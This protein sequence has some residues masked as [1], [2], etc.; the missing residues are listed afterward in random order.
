MDVSKITIRKVRQN[1]ASAFPDIEF[2]YG[3]DGRRGCSGHCISWVGGPTVETIRIAAGAPV[4]RYRGAVTYHFIREHAP[5]EM[6]AL[7]T[8]WDEEHRARVA[9]EPARRATAKA[10]GIEKRKATVA[11]KK[12]LAAKLADA[13]PGVDFTLSGDNVSWTDGPERAEVVT[14]AGVSYGQTYRHVTTEF[15]NRLAERLATRVQTGRLARRLAASKVRA[16]GVAIARRR[17]LREVAVR[18]A[19]GLPG[20]NSSLPSYSALG[21]K[22]TMTP[23]TPW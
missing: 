8:Q 22:N 5:E 10:A 12:A 14:A 7:R 18:F 6:E 15:L 1:L 23:S 4:F 9:A 21:W 20:A 13:F 17:R 19:F 3:K 16:I 2:S 11:A